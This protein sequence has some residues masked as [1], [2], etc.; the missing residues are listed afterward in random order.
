MP[1]K[2]GVADEAR[3][4]R[5]R[6]PDNPYVAFHAPRFAALLTLLDDYVKPGMLVLDIGRSALTGLM[7]ERFGVQVDCLGFHKN[8]PSPEGHN[9]WY[10]LNLAADPEKWRTDLPSYDVIVMG[11]VIEH[12]YTAP[13]LVLSFLR[14]LLKDGGV[15]I[16]QTPNAAVLHKRV[17]LLLGR[18][19]YEL[20]RERQNDPG[21]FREY[22]RKELVAAVESAGLQVEQWFAADYLDYSR[23]GRPGSRAARLGTVVNTVYRLSPPSLKPGQTLVARRRELAD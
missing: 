17:E 10:D 14:S 18:N 2:G 15:L 12:L 23:K 7:H 13:R 4:L 5:E 20:I 11:E 6:F 8:G 3:Q 19:P 21:H 22:T 9:W 16:I 1:K